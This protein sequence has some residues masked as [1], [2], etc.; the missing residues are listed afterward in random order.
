MSNN[1]ISQIEADM[2]CSSVCDGV[3]QRF[4]TLRRRVAVLIKS[5]SGCRFPGRDIGMILDTFARHIRALVLSNLLDVVSVLVD[6][7]TLAA[8]GSGTRGSWPQ[9][10]AQRS[11]VLILTS[12]SQSWE[13]DRYG[14]ETGDIA[15]LLPGYAGL[16]VDPEAEQL[17]RPVLAIRSC[18]RRDRK[19]H[20][21]EPRLRRGRDEP[22]LDWK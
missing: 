19:R 20:G 4:P 9:V 10:H 22:Q 8:P 12:K 14:P 21:H 13:L 6:I 17:P 15:L 3:T 2:L 7:S 5:Q 11:S 1:N 16:P 18:N